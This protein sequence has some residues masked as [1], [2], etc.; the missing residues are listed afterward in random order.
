MVTLESKK[1]YVVHYQNLQQAI[2]NGLVVEK[3][4]YLLIKMELV[5]SKKLLQKR[6]NLTTFKHSIR[7][8]KLSM[9]YH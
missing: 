5:C 4:A 6:I 2:A 8:T 1:N 3:V 7:T 9:P